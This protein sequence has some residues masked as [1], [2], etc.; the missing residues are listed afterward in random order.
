MKKVLLTP[1]ETA[2]LIGTGK[3]LGLAGDEA[4]LDQMPKG[5]WIGGTVPY[6]IGEN[7]GV[8]CHDKIYVSVF[9]GVNPSDIQIRNYSE[10]DIQLIA[11]DAPENGF[12]FLV[13]PAATDI[14]LEFAT[15]SRDYE[16]MFVKPIVG[17]VS[18]VKLS[19]LGT[20]KPKVYNGR[21][22]QKFDDMGAAIHAKLPANKQAVI[23]ILNLFKQGVGDVIQFPDAGFSVTKCFV[24]GK[25]MMFAD[26]LEETQYDKRLPLVANYHGAH[27][28]CAIQ[29][30]DPVSKSVS[31]YAPVF[32]EAEYR[33]SSAIGDYV[34]QYEVTTSNLKDDP[35]FCCNCIL[36][37]LYGELEGRKTGAWTGPF[38]F[39]E[40]GYQLLN[41]T[42]VYLEINDIG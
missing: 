29:A 28:N 20:I 32:P 24:N 3:V 15:N 36:N 12:T 18:G 22:K 35:V 4:L 42:M 10:G 23:K 39:G 11:K 1:I 26:Y 30:V 14:N 41:Q 31:F 33:Q 16:D 5:N 34:K 7:G 21:T 6:F 2:H 17:W 19:D 40:I 27:I 8:E 13:L 38:T 25:P 9:E 37:Y